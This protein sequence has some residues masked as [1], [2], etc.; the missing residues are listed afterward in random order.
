MKTANILSLSEISEPNTLDAYK[1]YLGISLKDIEKECLNSLCSVF[2]KNSP[3]IGVFD[4]FYIGYTI[5]QISKEFDLLRIDENCVINI[6]LKS[7]STEEKIHKQLTQNS[8]YLSFLNKETHLFTFVKETQKLYKLNGAGELEIQDISYLISYL[9]KQVKLFTDDLDT[10]FNPSNYLVSPFNSTEKFMNDKYFLTEHQQ[11]MKTNINLVFSEAIGNIVSVTGKAGTGKT[12]LTYDCAKDFINNGKKV[13]IIHAG[14][15][16]DGQDLLVSDYNWE[17]IPIKRINYFLEHDIKATTY[18]II[19]LDEAQRAYKT[20]LETIINFASKNKMNCIMSYDE[21]QTLC[22]SEK[23]SGV[24]PYLSQISNI[25]HPLTNKIRTN[26]SL[27]YFISS[28]F[29]LKKTNKI[30]GNNISII[31][32]K[33]PQAA[34]KYI[35]TK[36]EYNFIMHTTSLHN[37]DEF[38][39]FEKINTYKGNS[40]RIIGQEFDNVI[41]IIDSVFYYDTDKRLQNHSRRGNPYDQERMLFQIVTRTRKNLEIVVINNLDVF[42]ELLNLI[43]KN[44]E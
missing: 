35:E 42:K 20:H 17:I 8:Y 9:E 3:A 18:D 16:N 6:E 11:K 10:L 30:K 33:D 41:T 14:N 22:Y 2:I 36:E 43:N 38:D 12:L 5:P 21:K 44:Q 25:K 32:F 37:K 29:D 27:A 13:L 26:K 24:I 34:K 31:H 19:I 28:M 23:N 40:H 39:E 1:N 4:N 7:E 15:L